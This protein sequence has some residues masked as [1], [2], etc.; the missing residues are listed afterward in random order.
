MVKREKMVRRAGQKGR[1]VQYKKMSPTF[2]EC[3]T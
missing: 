3:S 1:I 2:A